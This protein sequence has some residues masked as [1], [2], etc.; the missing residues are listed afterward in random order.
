MQTGLLRRI[1]RHTGALVR[2][3]EAR[4]QLTPSLDRRL[5]GSRL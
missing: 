4:E 5:A 1:E 3:V 2:H